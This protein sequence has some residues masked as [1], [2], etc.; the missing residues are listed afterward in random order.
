MLSGFNRTIITA[1][2][3]GPALSGAGGSTNIGT[4]PTSL[5]PAQARFPLKGQAITQ[6]GDKLRFRA[7][8]ILTTPGSPTTVAFSLMLDAVAVWTSGAVT[9]GASQTNATWKLDVDLD[10]R[11]VGAAAALLGIG[12]VSGSLASILPA[13]SPVNGNAFDATLPH[14]LDLYVT[15]GAATAGQT[16]QLLQYEPLSVVGAI[17]S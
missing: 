17:G 4:T 9:P 1:Q 15:L 7:A 3:S 13:T 5:L 14:Q 11:A 16:I 10:V 2:A 8:G 6:I 12:S